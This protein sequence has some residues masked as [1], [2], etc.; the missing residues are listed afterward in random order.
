M[1]FHQEALDVQLSLSLSFRQLLTPR[2]GSI[3]SS[4]KVGIKKN[5]THTRFLPHTLNEVT[6]LYITSLRSLET[7][8]ILRQGILLFGKGTQ[9]AERHP[10]LAFPQSTEKGIQTA[11]CRNQNVRDLLTSCPLLLQCPCLWPLYSSGICF[12]SC[13]SLSLR[14]RYCPPALLVHLPTQHLLN[15]CCAPGTTPGIEDRKVKKTL[16]LPLRGSHF[17][18]CRG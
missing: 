15:T 8:L 10:E 18:E 4:G 9:Q 12:C 1:S 6:L 17:V 3:N 5:Q 14:C 7:C 16:S 2:L 13:C 11:L